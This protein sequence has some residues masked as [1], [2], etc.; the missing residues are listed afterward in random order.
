[1]VTVLG[2]M[3]ARTR[4]GAWA[5]RRSMPRGHCLCD[6]DF[7]VCTRSW[8]PRLMWQYDCR[9]VAEFMS[10][11]LALMPAPA[12]QVV[13]VAKSDN[14][15]VLHNGVVCMPFGCQL[16]SLPG[17]CAM[18]PQLYDMCWCGCEHPA[19]PFVLCYCMALRAVL[20][21]INVQLQ[22]GVGTTAWPS[23][24]WFCPRCGHSCHCP[25]H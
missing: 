14:L 12:P 1:M 13:P 24:R 25:E 18:L 11:S 6:C 3:Y 22:T 8:H 23:Q 5:V 9:L 19:L 17:P 2:C 20:K 7:M 21:I 10:S 15:A 16:S 4:G